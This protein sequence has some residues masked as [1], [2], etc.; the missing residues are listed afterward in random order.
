[1]K[2]L[3]FLFSIASVTLA[4][5]LTFNLPASASTSLRR[6]VPRGDVF[7]HHQSGT[8]VPDSGTEGEAKDSP[9]LFEFFRR[10]VI[11]ET[12]TATPGT[13]TPIITPTKT[14]RP[15][16]TPVF[17]PPPSDPDYLRLM[18]ALGGIMVI[19]L[20]VGVWINREHRT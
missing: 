5:I 19:V 8:L 4:L 18:I 6:D 15:T 3:P 7:E 11:T 16:S 1:M 9:S 12:P 14:P 10:F 17:V 20:L 2:R 13:P